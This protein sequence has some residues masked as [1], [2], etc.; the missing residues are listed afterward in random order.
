MPWFGPLT[1]GSAQQQSAPAA[2]PSEGWRS[3]FSTPILLKLAL[4]VAIADATSG[5][6]WPAQPPPAAPVVYQD[7][8]RSA[9]SLPVRLYQLPRQQGFVSFPGVAGSAISEGWRSE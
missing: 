6:V 5:V 1:A 8:W 2:A 7:G 3:Q 9:F 4:T